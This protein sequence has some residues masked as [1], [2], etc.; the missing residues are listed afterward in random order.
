[1]SG[2]RKR[3]RWLLLPAALALASLA[4]IRLVRP[5]GD[6]VLLVTFDTLR[7]DHL[8]CYGGSPS[9]PAMDALAD[10]GVLIE[11]AATNI[12]RTTPALATIFTGRYPQRHGVRFLHQRLDPSQPVLSEAMRE[13]GLRTGAFVA[14]GPLEPATGLDRGFGT[15]R[16]Y[17]D[18]KAA[19]LGLRAAA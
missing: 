4:G 14:G 6:D 15:Y 17:V 3:G 18:L 8:G 19:L 1:M 5:A 16:C 9:T 13:A 2:F 7:A 12:P 11:Q 10:S